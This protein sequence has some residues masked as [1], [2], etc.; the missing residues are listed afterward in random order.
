MYVEYTPLWNLMILPAWIFTFV[1]CVWIYED[2]RKYETKAA[3]WIAA[4][5]AVQFFNPSVF[6]SLYYWL[7]FLPSQGVPMGPGSV[8]DVSSFIEPM[9]IY[10]IAFLWETISSYFISLTVSALV[11]FWIYVDAGKSDIRVTPWIFG[12][13][14]MA[15]MP[16]PLSMVIPLGGWSGQIIILIV[17]ILRK[18]K[19]I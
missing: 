14:F 7:V 17:Y 8:F 5:L 6:I 16:F 12:V 19:Y 15:N 9:Y 1:Y 13:Q 10:D 11:T 3:S 2:S 18:H 4:T